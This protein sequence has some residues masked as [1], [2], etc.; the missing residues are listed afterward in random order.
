MD[1]ITTARSGLQAG[2]QVL[3]TAA[4]QIASADT[5]RPPGR[6]TPQDVLTSDPG[7]PAADPPGYV[8]RPNVDRA[9]QMGSLIVGQGAVEANATVIDR[10]LAAY[11][12]V[13]D[14]GRRTD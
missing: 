4:G 6:T 7:N 10:A 12:S 3:D 2:Q 11:R 13:L 5:V 1:P 9:I 14:I 8:H